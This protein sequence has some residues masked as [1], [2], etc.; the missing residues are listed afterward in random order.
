[1]SQCFARISLVPLMLAAIACAFALSPCAAEPAAEAPGPIQLEVDA[2]QAPQKILHAHM[3]IPVRPGPLVLYYPE[4]IPGEHMPDGPIVDVAGLKF[5]GNG[6]A[7]PWRRDLLDMFAFHLDIPADV[8]MLD[9]H[10]DF[11]LSAPAT[12]Y[13][14][15]ASATA[16]LDLISWN[17]VV[18]Y[19]QGYP[20]RDLTYVPSLLL[21]AGWKF[22]TALPGAKM[23][24]DTIRFSPVPLDTLV[25]SPV[26]AG[27]NFR[28]IDL[29]PGE[30]PSHEID[31]AA[32]SPAGLA[33]RP[34]TEMHFRRLVAETG[35]LFGV[36][37][38]RDYHFLLTLSDDVAHFGLE[39]HES[40]DDR[41]DARSLIDDEELIDF[42]DLLPHEFVHS[43]NGKYRRPA[44]LATPD[45][46]QPMKDDLLWVYEGLTEYLGE[47]LTAR[48]GLRNMEQ[49]RE[50]LARIATENGASPGR[51][52]RP[53]QDTADSA[54][55]LYDA[56]SDWENWRRGV[57]FY[58]E[59]ELLWLDVDTTM[60]R[61]TNDAKS[62][63][64]FCRAFYGGPG[65]QPALK[66]YTFDDI[67]AA[68]NELAPYD[69]AG[70]LRTRLDS[71]PADTPTE[72][73]QNAGWKIVYNDEPNEIEEVKDD[74]K[75]KVTLTF[76]IGLTLSDDGSIDDVL[77][78]G[79]AY[80]A[81]IGPN[82]K[83]A[84]VNGQQ[85]SPDTLKDAIEA[86]EGTTAPIRLIV[87]NGAQVEMHQIDYHGGLRYPHL[88]RDSSHPDY[89]GEIFHRLAQ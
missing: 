45:Y 23:D 51:D 16:Y 35:A 66:T 55:F 27:L 4:W 26:L 68:L 25:D 67:V 46:H 15:G 31:I 30:Q 32:D 14:A 9:I 54:P 71:V 89:L 3:Q 60:R 10:L 49:S 81:G 48:S 12:G 13:S 29:T 57:D 64:D 21:P 33:M 22:G 39:H 84:A 83:V 78:D 88:R 18:L 20:V 77:Y 62:M 11:L 34:E 74:V 17:Q 5:A 70:F 50:D 24:G 82:M 58:E 38:Y 42:S 41:S 6:K 37:H 61:L 72:A 79:P 53:L 44:D 2:R 76:S 28:V 75:R 80:K 43:W 52:W 1:M 73:L 85:Y 7:I 56:D 40:S 65:G 63:N 59:G 86:A 87:A 36:R 69:W 19:P 8:K 47:V